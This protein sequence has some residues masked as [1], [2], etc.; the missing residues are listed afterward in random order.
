MKYVH[1]KQLE[2][3]D[4]GIACVS[5]VLKFYNVKYGINYLRDQVISKDGYSLKD[6][7][8]LFNLF[9]DFSCKAIEIDIKHVEEVFKHIELPCIALINKGENGYYEGHYI[10]IYKLKN[11]KILISDPSNDKITK[12]SIEEFKKKSTGVLLLIN[13]KEHNIVYGQN[14]QKKFLE[15]LIKS[16]KLSLFTIFLF[17]AL[18][19]ILSISNSFFFKVLI[20]V[21][22]PGNYDYFLLQLTLIFLGINLTSNI[23]DYLRIY[24]INKAAIKL[25]LS[26][27]KEFFKKIVTLPITFFENRDDGD[28]ISR[29]NDTSYIRNLINV[30]FVSIILN[31]VIFLGIGFVLYKLNTVLFFT[32]LSL[33]L[34]LISLTAMY[35]DILQQKNKDFM[36]KKANTQSFLIQS[37]KNMNNIYSLNKKEYFLSTFKKIY[38]H[39]LDATFKEAITITNNNG[40]KRLVQSSFSIILLFVGAKQ[41]MADTISLGDLLFIN[42]LTLFMMNSLG[43]LIELQGEIQKALVAKERFLDIMNYPVVLNKKNT[44]IEKVKKIAIHNLNFGINDYCIIEN[45]NIDL[46]ENEKV[47]LIGESGSGKTTFSKILNKLYPANQSQIFIN[48]VDINNIRDTDLRNEITYLNENPFLFK[49]TIKENLCMGKHFNEQEIINACKKAH[50]YEVILSLPRGFNFLINNGN[51][52]LSTGQKQRLCLA[53]AILHKPSVLILDEALCNVDPNNYINIYKDLL[54]LD[55]ILIFITHNLDSLTQ[56]DRKFIFKNKSIFEVESHIEKQLN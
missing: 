36:S 14:Y 44:E 21:I 18:F 12:L 16:N 50:V 38:N 52:N 35:Y 28:I 19:V 7:I 1:T 5:S 43:G 51:S 25:D 53:R 49:D 34:I 24:I 27:S 15:G 23:F 46:F 3:Y 9:D 26:I 11:K 13:Q 10:V 56:Y 31:S 33:A 45:V 29:F 32:V 40:I 17:S 20:D 22:I 48:D 2:K 4:C 30:A 37:I 8:S 55:L 39:Q 54:E 6:L 47:V 41:V 42:S